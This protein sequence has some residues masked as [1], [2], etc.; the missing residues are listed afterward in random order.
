MMDEPLW[1]EDDLDSKKLFS[2]ATWMDEC[3]DHKKD[4]HD[5]FKRRDS[6]LYEIQATL[7][8]IAKIIQDEE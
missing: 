2:L 6:H 8:R 1:D 4:P 7:R 5:L 3:R